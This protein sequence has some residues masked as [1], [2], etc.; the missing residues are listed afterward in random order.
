M[1]IVILIYEKSL[2]T[3]YIS[4]LQHTY[5]VFH[6]ITRLLHY[7]P[8][9][10]ESKVL[11]DDLWFA[12]GL[13]ISPDNQFVVVAETSRYKLTKYYISGPKKGK[14]ETFIAGLPGEIKLVYTLCL[15]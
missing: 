1:S 3:I 11:L 6:I 7:N 5:K 14:S 12:N 15:K 9:K 8:T 4:L 10:N 2:S 13:A